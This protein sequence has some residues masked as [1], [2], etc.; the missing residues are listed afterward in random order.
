MMH[1][2]NSNAAVCGALLIL[3]LLLAGPA[4]RAPFRSSSV[5]HPQDFYGLRNGCQGGVD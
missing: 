1:Y 2:K 4:V 5:R 3:G